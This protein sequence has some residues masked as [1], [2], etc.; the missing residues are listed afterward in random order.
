MQYQDFLIF[1]PTF[2]DM[3]NLELTRHGT[4]LRIAL[5]NK[6]TKHISS[7]TRLEEEDFVY[8]IMDQDIDLVKMKTEIED[9]IAIDRD[10]K[11]FHELMHL[12]DT[13]TITT[14]AKKTEDESVKN[15]LIKVVDLINQLDR[16][17][18][19]LYETER[20]KYPNLIPF[21]GNEAVEELFK[22]AVNEGLLTE[23]Y[24]PAEGT[25]RFQLKLIAIAVMEIT[26]LPLRNR[27][28]KFQ[29]Q[30]KMEDVRLSGISIPLGKT[31]EIFR[32]IKLYPEVNFMRHIT[33]NKEEPALLKTDLTKKQAAN[34]FD[35]LMTRGY[36]D[37]NTKL[38]SF[39]AFMGFIK[40]PFKK[41]NW[42]A[43]TQYSLIYLSSLL[44]SDLNGKWIK[45]ICNS[46]TVNNAN[47]NAATIKTR[48]SYIGRHREEYEF[49]KE[50]DTLLSSIRRNKKTK[51]VK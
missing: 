29:E 49:V 25:S 19:E 33:G 24:Q 17:G 28:C 36:L 20:G 42:I 2:D 35:Q 10:P 18:N 38:E 9:Y 45:P 50:F 22:R 44:F 6:I 48:N 47:L 26:N 5:F 23:D 8:D 16:F 37:K 43:P 3:D 13:S 1:L 40:I 12:T 7:A 39:L 11:L 14:F 27:W 4:A 51:Y 30:W 34:L 15:W 21:L 41:I 32:V 46:F 31:P